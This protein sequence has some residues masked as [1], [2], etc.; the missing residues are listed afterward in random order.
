MVCVFSIV[1]D[2]GVKHNV[3]RSFL[4]DLNMFSIVKTKVSDIMCNI[5]LYQAKQQ[6]IG[7]ITNVFL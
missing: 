5:I 3:E 1:E 6:R 2:K 4:Y 7:I